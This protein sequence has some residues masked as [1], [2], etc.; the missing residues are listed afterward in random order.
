LPCS[1]GQKVRLS[2]FKVAQALVER[3]APGAPLDRPH[4]A[5]EP[6]LDVRQFFAQAPVLARG[7]TLEIGHLLREGAD[8]LRDQFWRQQTVLQAG[9]HP[10]LDPL[11]RDRAR[12]VARPL[13]PPRRAAVTVLADH[14]V[15]ATAVATGQQTAQQEAPAMH[16]VQRVAIGIASHLK[17][18]VGLTGPNTIPK[19]LIDDP[20]VWDFHFLALLV[21]IDPR[22]TP[23]GPRVLDIAAAVP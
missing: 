10:L 5:L 3:L 19:N 7:L 12:I 18:N 21:G 4:D 17:V 22:Q 2:G 11:A 6:P 9:Q 13:R 15:A 1:S 20:E 14:R 8:E 16:A 23:P